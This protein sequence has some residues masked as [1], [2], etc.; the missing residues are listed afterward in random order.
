MKFAQI[1]AAARRA[2]RSIA[3]TLA[4]AVAVFMHATAS[5]AAEDPEV[6]LL[7][8]VRL[9]ALTTAPEGWMLCDGQLLKVNENQALFALLG[10]TF[11]GDGR[12]TYA[13]PNL[14][15]VKIGDGEMRYY[16]AVRGLFPPR[17]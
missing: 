5:R 13:L 15:P 14:P 16:I 11:G 8:E 9:M 17:Q 10:P 12:Q 4:I 2:P 7:G 6:V 3:W 1:T